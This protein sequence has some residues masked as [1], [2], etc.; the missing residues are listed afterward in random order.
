MDDVAK[1][2]VYIGQQYIPDDLKKRIR[3]LHLAI[4]G[5]NVTHKLVGWT[6]TAMTFGLYLMGWKRVYYR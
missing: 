1:L 3:N 4:T 5:A 6:L 2:E